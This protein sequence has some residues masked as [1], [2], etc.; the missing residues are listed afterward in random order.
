[1]VLLYYSFI[2]PEKFVLSML[3]MFLYFLG[4]DYCIQKKSTMIFKHGNIKNDV[5]MN[6]NSFKKDRID[7]EKKYISDGTFDGI[8]SYEY[9]SRNGN[10]K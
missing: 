5:L 4:T 9:C 6:N 10:G 1:M 8:S 2:C 7:Y 3:F